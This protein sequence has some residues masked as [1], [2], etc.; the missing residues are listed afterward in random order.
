M[1]KN[2]KPVKRR[3]YFD[4]TLLVITLFLVAFGLVM[5]Y[6]TSSYSAALKFNDSF[7][8]FKRQILSVIVGAVLMIFAIFIPYQLY[9]KLYFIIYWVGIAFIAMIFTPIGY[10]AN[11]AKRWLRFGPIS[12]QPSEICKL[13]VI[14]F[15]A[16]LLTKMGKNVRRKIK[17]YL[18]CMVP[19][20]IISALILFVTKNMSSALIIGIIG[21]LIYWVGEKKSIW[22]AITMGGI[23]A[24]CVGVV[25]VVKFGILPQSM[26]FRLERVMAWMDPEANAGGKGM[27]ILQSLYGIG[28]GGVWGKGLGKSMQ[29]LGFLPESQ[30]D[31][32]FSII[33]EELG[34]V[35]GLSIMALFILLLWRI[36]E[37]SSHSKDYFGSL[38]IAGIFSHIAVQV[39]LNISVVTNTIPNTG[40]ALPFISYG[41]TSVIVLM[42]EIGIVLNVGRQ[43]QFVE[44]DTSEAETSETD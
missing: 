33:C 42:T 30:N 10:E 4:V 11:G 44:E 34:V 26:S 29:K 38:L 37:V 36:R 35:G 17:G 27:Q 25:A 19:V 31:M 12:I 14:V 9:R 32:I 24:A 15:V 3:G 20:G 43:A 7:Y 1:D 21:I 2:N 8:Y 16:A 28:S 39:L 13:C 40:I 6:S 5:V 18:V 22:P 41:G 23:V